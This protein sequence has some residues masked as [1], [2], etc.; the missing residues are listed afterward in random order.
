MDLRL[1][2]Q[3][4]LRLTATFEPDDSCFHEHFPGNPVVPGS[5]VVG[6]CMQALREHR[7]ETGP[8]LL[9]RFSFSRFASPGSYDLCIAKQESGYQCTL[10]QGELIFAQGRIEA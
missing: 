10:S 4:P 8:L 5:L 1:V 7:S 2:S 6:L 9:K 3:D